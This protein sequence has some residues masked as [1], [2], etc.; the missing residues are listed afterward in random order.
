MLAVL[1][2]ALG[3]FA[4][5]DLAW[6]WGFGD[7]QTAESDGAIERILIG[8]IHIIKKGKEKIRQVPS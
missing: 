8:L 2:V 7:E 4:G 1:A 5:N 6:F 3:A